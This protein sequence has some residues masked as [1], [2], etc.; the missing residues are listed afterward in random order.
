MNPRATHYLDLGSQGRCAWWRYLAGL[1][2]ILSCW[3][4]LGQI[5]YAFILA[6]RITDPLADFIAINFT[7][8]MMLA[9]LAVAMRWLHGRPLRS[10][11]TP[12]RRVDWWR[13]G[14]GAAAWAALMPHSME[15]FQRPAR[16]Q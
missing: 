7:I 3:F 16:P 10:L 12:A 8:L 11:V 13:V 6:P 9:G 15:H 4:G 14:Q 1:L 5:P 2:L